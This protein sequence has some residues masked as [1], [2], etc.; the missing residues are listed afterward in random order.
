MAL[1]S[2]CRNWP[3]LIICGQILMCFIPA[4]QMKNH[5]SDFGSF[6]YVG[7]GV[8]R[9]LN[10]FKIFDSGTKCGWGYWTNTEYQTNTCLFS[11]ATFVKMY[12]HIIV[13][14]AGFHYRDLLLDL[15]MQH[16]PQLEV[17]SKKV[18]QNTQKNNFPAANWCKIVQWNI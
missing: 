12:E 16:V 18:T 13:V 17:N 10:E 3:N 11:S 15:F 2:T 9:S 4:S 7:Y 5:F 8:I 14:V 1:V 6:L